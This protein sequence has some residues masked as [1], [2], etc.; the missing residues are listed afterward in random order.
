MPFYMKILEVDGLSAVITTLCSASQRD[1][2]IIG[3]FAGVKGGP[4]NLWA[5]SRF[6][7]DLA[8]IP[9]TVPIF[10][11]RLDNRLFPDP[12]VPK[13]GLL[14]SGLRMTSLDKIS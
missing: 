11:R 4:F 9:V 12:Q 13:V 1:I 3:W 8:G 7:R 14:N 2:G 6:S 10:G 5:T